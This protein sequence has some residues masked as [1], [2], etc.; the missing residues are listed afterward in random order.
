[1]QTSFLLKGGATFMGEAKA[2]N[3][4]KLAS[5]QRDVS[6]NSTI[7]SQ[8]SAILT[9]MGVVGCFCFLHEKVPHSRAN[10]RKLRP[11]FLFG[12]VCLG[13]HQKV[14]LKISDSNSEIVKPRVWNPNTPPLPNPLRTPLP[15]W[16]YIGGT[17]M[18]RA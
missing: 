18:W 5:S 9:I 14:L 6:R 15:V 2:L 11:F 4:P 7:N 13:G 10:G 3:D 17:S 12:L 16:E 8:M 1:M